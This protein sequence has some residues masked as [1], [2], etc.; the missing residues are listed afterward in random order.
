MYNFLSIWEIT[1]H[2]V[3][4]NADDKQLQLYLLAVIRKAT[5]CLVINKGDWHTVVHS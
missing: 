3:N 1:T 2:S 5:L 4:A